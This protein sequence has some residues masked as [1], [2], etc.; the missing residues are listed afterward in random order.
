M[1]L[2]T[3]TNV[4]RHAQQ[5]IVRGD[6]RVVNK[7]QVRRDL[8]QLCVR[9][10][11]GTRDGRIRRADIGMHKGIGQGSVQVTPETFYSAID[12]ILC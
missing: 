11:N 4:F 12:F 1:R 2:T 10:Q 3:L 8:L 9:S 5:Q 7:G 6:V